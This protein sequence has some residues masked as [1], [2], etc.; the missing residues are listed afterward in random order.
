ML[1][2]HQGQVPI[3]AYSYRL[4]TL[5]MRTRQAEF[6]ESQDFQF[7]DKIQQQTDQISRIGAS[8]ISATKR[9]G[10]ERV[11]GGVELYPDP[12]AQFEVQTSRLPI[13]S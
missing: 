11:D 6:L 8:T 3:R 5:R 10:L 12:T 1:G 4:I 2:R 13:A 9:S 7:R